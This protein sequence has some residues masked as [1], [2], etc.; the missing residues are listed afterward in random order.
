MPILALLA[1]KQTS[2]TKQQDDALCFQKFLKHSENLEKLS[3]VGLL[4]QYQNILVAIG[5][6]NVFGPC[7]KYH[8]YSIGCKTEDK[9]IETH[10]VLV[11][12][13]KCTFCKENEEKM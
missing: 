6:F 7:L 12:S 4:Q 5:T 2:D 13:A 3:L 1:K 11:S 8:S 9:H 10:V